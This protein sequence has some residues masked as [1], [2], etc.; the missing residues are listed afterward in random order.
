MNDYIKSILG[1]PLARNFFVYSF[2]ALFL[3]GVSFLLLPLYTELLS[4]AEYG[5]LDLLSTFA[6]ILDVSLSLGL[7]SVII[8][9]YYHFDEETRKKMFHN[10][11]SIFLTLSSALYLVT[12][13]VVLIN[14]ESIFPNVPSSLIVFVTAT[15]YLTFFQSFIVLILK[16][17][18][19][20]A[21]VTILQIVS[22]SASILLN[23]LFVY[24][25]SLGVA[26]II[27]SSFI[28]V[29][30]FSIYSWIFIFK[31]LSFKYD[32]NRAI[33]IKYLK[34]GLPFVPNALTLWLMTSANRWILLKYSTLESV[35]FFSVAFKFSSLFDPLIIQPFLAAYTPRILQRFK[36]GDFEQPIGK[37]LLFGIPGFIAA[38]FALQV[39][40]RFMINEEFYSALAFIPILVFSNY[41]SLMAQVSAYILVF[42]KR[43]I[44]MVT[45]ISTAAIIGVIANFI[46]VPTMGG[47]GSAI[48]ANIG[49]FVWFIIIYYLQK[50]ER[51]QLALNGH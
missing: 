33:L 50:R 16:Q 15:S 29:L 1:H 9:E 2:G 34:L 30:A 11:I 46:L 39:I 32:L 18:E 4:P 47:M 35:G 44:A 8:I 48:A 22:G 13:A 40:A 21:F 23:V 6:N 42:Q 27:W 38:G 45:A 24:G 51:N 25:L 17:Q 28:G 5:I 14:S 20:A 43:V 31:K 10:I 19:K 7:L 36:R 37:I 49:G 3:K 12:L 26:G 41:F